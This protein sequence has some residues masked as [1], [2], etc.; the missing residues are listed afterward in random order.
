MN[1]EFIRA[2]EELEKE[3]GISKD[4]LIEAIEIALV[5]A[6]KKNYGTSQNVRVCIDRE[7]GEIDVLM[8]KD[9]VEA[10]EDDLVEISLEEAM[11]I[12]KR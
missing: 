1:R 5:S 10:V 7:E 4:I 11:E 9:V 12:D 8:R 3:K 6:Y 2:I